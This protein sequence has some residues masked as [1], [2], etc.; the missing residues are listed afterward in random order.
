MAPLKN[1]RLAWCVALASLALWATSVPLTWGQHSA[2]AI[3]MLDVTST[4]TSLDDSQQP[5][6][7]A[8]PCPPAPAPP[9]EALPPAIASLLP[10]QTPPTAAPA[11]AAPAASSGTA[12][13]GSFHL[14]GPDASTAHDIEHLIAGRSFSASLSSTADGCADLM[15]R[16]TS[17]VGNG[18]ATS[19]LSVSLGSGQNLQ[20]QITSQNGATHV[21]IGSGQ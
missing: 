1:P 20:I 19:Q 15:I 21:S 10:A 2:D 3:R 18:S 5:A 9:V 17:P 7:A 16:P 13:Q 8:T 6:D 12:S 14:C 4:T 11:P